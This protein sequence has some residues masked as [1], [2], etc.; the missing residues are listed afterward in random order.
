MDPS[1]I[2]GRG[3]VRFNSGSYTTNTLKNPALPAWRVIWAMVRFRPLL[4][5]L[6]LAAIFLIRAAWQIIPGWP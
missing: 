5:L 4:W 1:P 3:G 2:G 6:D